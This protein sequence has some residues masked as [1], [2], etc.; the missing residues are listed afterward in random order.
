MWKI[1]P[2]NGVGSSFSAPI[3]ETWALVH[4][5][6]LYCFWKITSIYSHGDIWCLA[7]SALLNDR[8][9][10]FAYHIDLVG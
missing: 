9:Q 4:Q 3:R 2:L 6:L 7:V 1:F 8:L 10:G 5:V